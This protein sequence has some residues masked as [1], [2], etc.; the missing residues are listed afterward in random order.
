VGLTMTAPAE[1]TGHCVNSACSQFEVPKDMS[2]M[3]P[4][5]TDPVWCGQCG[6]AISIN[7]EPP[8][9]T[10]GLVRREPEEIHPF[11]PEEATT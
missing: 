6:E 7:G 9:D 2:G 4:D 8:P 11:K 10:A 5:W 1:T 3:P